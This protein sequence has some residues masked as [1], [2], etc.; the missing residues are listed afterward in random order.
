MSTPTDPKF[1][2]LKKTLQHLEGKI[3]VRVG[4]L[5]FDDPDD[6]TA[7]VL[8]EHA[9]IWS[10]E[11]FWT[12]P[13]G[14]VEFGESLKE[15]LIR[16]VKEETGLDI[17]IGPLRYVLDFVRPPLHAVSFY[18]EC[19]AIDG[20]GTLST[21]TDPELEGNQLIRAVRLVSFEE[22]GKLNVYPEGL[23]ERLP[24]DARAGIPR[25][26]QYLGTLR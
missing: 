3:R 6:P 20:S 26:V 13:G 23:A 19:L 17:E 16:E 21:G 7:L 9:G 12:P 18:F 11:P 24:A 1:I 8:V 22:L 4:G 15:A 5:L 2:K 10:D 25:R 14:G